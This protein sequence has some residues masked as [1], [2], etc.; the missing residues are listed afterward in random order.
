MELFQRILT[1]DEINHRFIL[2]TTAILAK[3]LIPNKTALAE[4][5][6]IKPAKFSEIL[7]GRMKA[8]T[9]MLATMCDL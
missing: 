4:S 5:L 3:Q 6:N 9:D 8:G 2:A 1:K 7:N